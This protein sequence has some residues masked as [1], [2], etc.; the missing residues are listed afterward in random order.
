MGLDYGFRGLVYYHHG[1]EHG[2]KKTN[3]GAVVESYILTCRQREKERE[4]E[5]EGEGEGE[6]ED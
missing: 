1:R 5:E 4:R 3:A 6:G 2:D